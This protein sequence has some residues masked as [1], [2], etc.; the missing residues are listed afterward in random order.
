MGTALGESNLAFFDLVPCIMPH[1]YTMDYRQLPAPTYRIGMMVEGEGT[2]QLDGGTVHFGPREMVFIPVGSTYISHWT[3]DPVVNFYTLFFCFNDSRFFLHRK[4]TRLQTLS[5]PEPETM[6]ADFADALEAYRSGP[7]SWYRTMG[8]FY[9]LLARI[10]PMLQVTD[11]A[12]LDSRIEQAALYLE[13][14]YR[15]AFPIDVLA[16]LCRMS[17]SH[18]YAL[19]RQN[20]GCTPIAY[21]Q[22]ISVARAEMLLVAE[23]E[24]S[25]EEISG[26]LGYHSSI[27]FREIFKKFHG[28]PP[29]DYR[30]LRLHE[31]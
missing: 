19:F 25:I 30:K 14:H 26:E 29:S 8:F 4:E 18:F 3:P 13:Q 24:K 2:F 9:S 7:G 28:I 27:Y 20:M 10:T 21:K 15:E 11:A 5:F 12:V 1:A 23:P 31:M 6:L 22:K 16:D 17:T